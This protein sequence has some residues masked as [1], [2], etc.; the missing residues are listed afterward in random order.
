MTFHRD[1]LLEFSFYNLQINMLYRWTF[2]IQDQRHKPY[3]LHIINRDLPML[4]TAVDL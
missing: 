2:L 4:N 3:K 1:F